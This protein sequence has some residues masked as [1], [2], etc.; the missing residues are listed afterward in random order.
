MDIKELRSI[1]IEEMHKSDKL[2]N[3]AE[4]LEQLIVTHHMLNR[5]D[6]LERVMPSF[7][8]ERR[9]ELK[10]S[11]QDVADQTSIA[12]STISRIERGK[13]AYFNTV[14]KLDKFYSDN[15]A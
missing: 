5:N 1:F 4:W 8:K 14:I 7:F 10:M 15:G 11:M 9:Q 3:Y 12:K 13:D 6:L 2:I